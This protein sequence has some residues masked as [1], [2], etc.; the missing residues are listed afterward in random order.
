MC[1]R[2][3]KKIE[4]L[5]C[6]SCGCEITIRQHILSDFLIGAHALQTGDRKIVTH[7]AGYYSTYFPELDII[8]IK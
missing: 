1:R 6:E 4:K 2:C 8:S 5:I 7:D 3:G